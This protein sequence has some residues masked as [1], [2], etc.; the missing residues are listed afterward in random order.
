M[1]AYIS[2]F[3]PNYISLKRAAVV[4]AREESGVDPDEIM[5]MFRHA[6]FAREFARRN[7]DSRHGTCR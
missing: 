2:P 7:R 1:P 3:D 5:E 6:I 4:I